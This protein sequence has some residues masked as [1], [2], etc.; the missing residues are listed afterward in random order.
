MDRSFG[1]FQLI[2]QY[3][4]R[5]VIDFEELK[6]PVDEMGQLIYGIEQGNRMFQ[7]QQNEWSHSLSARASL[8]LFYETLNLEVFSLMHFTTDEYMVI[9]KITYSISDGLSIAAG[10][11]WYSGVDNTLYN[12]IENPFNSVFLQLKAFF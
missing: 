10:M 7:M 4:G 6:P 12:L 2:L 5:Y 11:E 8:N 3:I 1:N 9:P